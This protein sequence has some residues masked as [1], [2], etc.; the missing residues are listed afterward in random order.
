MGV[1]ARKMFGWAVGG[2]LVP[3]SGG[4]SGRGRLRASD[5]PV[6]RRGLI[7]LEL[8]HG[9]G[10]R[11][12]E[13]RGLVEVEFGL[14]RAASGGHAGRPMRQVKME[15]DALYGGREGD[16]RDDLHLATADG[17]QEREHLVDASQKLGPEDAA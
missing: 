4:R 13:G 10:S 9:F 7:E 5:L 14:G 6:V 8:R 15:E 2:R 11:E 16:P 12:V 3:G 1:G 17:T